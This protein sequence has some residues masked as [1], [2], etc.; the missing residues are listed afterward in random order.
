[1]P[2]I[3][4]NNLDE[5]RKRYNAIKRGKSVERKSPSVCPLSAEQ[6]NIFMDKL[7]GILA[8]VYRQEKKKEV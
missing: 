8:N 7:A 3:A 6:E 2:I 4:V 5:A 1:M